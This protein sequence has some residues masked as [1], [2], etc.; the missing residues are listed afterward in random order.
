M[1]SISFEKLVS[2]CDQCI[3]FSPSQAAGQPNEPRLAAVSQPMEQVFCDLFELQGS[4]FML[5]ADAF[6]GYML[7]KKLQT[8]TAEKVIAKLHSWFCTVR[9]ARK[10]NFDGGPPF[11]SAQLKSYLKDHR[12]THGLSLVNHPNSNPLAEIS[13][14]LAKGVLKKIRAGHGKSKRQ[15]Q[16]A[17]YHL[18]CQA[19]VKGYSPADLFFNRKLRSG[20][21]PALHASLTGEELQRQAGNRLSLT[22]IFLSQTKFNFLICLLVLRLSFRTLLA[23]TG[24]GNGGARW[25]EKGLGGEAG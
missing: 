5:M 13:V 9:F 10:A 20:L 15:A 8:T 19:R 14:K 22:H 17:I 6:S 25:W 21:L 1:H 23:V 4:K 16:A 18:T 11:N 3:L 2:K 12:V 24:C 7:I